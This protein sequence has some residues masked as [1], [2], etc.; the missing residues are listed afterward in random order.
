MNEK[1]ISSLTNA[2]FVPPSKQ[3]QKCILCVVIMGKIFQLP[4]VVVWFI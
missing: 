4:V 1:L 3:K 2:S